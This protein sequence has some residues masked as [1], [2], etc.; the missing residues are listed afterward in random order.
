[1]SA[2]G[3]VLEFLVGLAGWS[4]GFVQIGLIG[5]GDEGRVH[6]M[7]DPFPPPKP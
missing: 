4:L 1:M 7:E 2:F 6:A 3:A 5:G